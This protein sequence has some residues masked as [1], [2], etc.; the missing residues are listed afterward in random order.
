MIFSKYRFVSLLLFILFFTINNRG[1]AQTNTLNSPL[2]SSSNVDSIDFEYTLSETPQKVQ[3]FF[4]C[5]DGP[6]LTSG[7]LRDTLTIT[8]NL[9]Y[10]LFFITE[11]NLTGNSF[12][13]SNQTQLYNGYYSVYTQFKR[14]TTGD[15][16]NSL[17]ST[18]VYLDHSTNAPTLITPSSNTSL[19]TQIPISLTL[20]E[21]PASGTSKLTFTNTAGSYSNTLVLANGTLSQ[22]FTLTSNS[23][24]TSGSIASSTFPTLPND[25]YNITLSYQD[26]FNHPAVTA[27]NSNVLIQ[28]STTIPN[29]TSPSTGAVFSSNNSPTFTYNLPSAPL[30]GTA[31]LS[32]TSSSGSS[33][34]YT[35]P[36][37][38]GSGTYTITSN[39][40]ADG[41]YTATVSYQD[42]LS[43]PVSSTSV[44][45]L[46]FD[47]I[48]LSP[49]INAP[50]TSTVSTGTV[51]FTYTL[52]ET[53]LNNSKQLKISQNGTIITILTV[54][55][56]NTSTL[57]LN[58]KNL[59]T[60]ASAITTITGTSNIPDGTYS[61]TFSYQDQYSNAVASASI[62]L[63]IDTRTVAPILSS[64]L[65]GSYYSSKIPISLTLG[66]SYLS[67]SAKIIFVNSNNLRD[68][69]TLVDNIL[70][71][72]FTITTKN[73]LN[74]NIISTTK[75]I[76]PDEIY[77][78]IIQYQD[79]YG[80]P[81][82]S[83]AVSNILI[84]NT[85]PIPS[86]TSP[87]NGGAFSG[88]SKISVSYNLPSAPFSGTALLTLSPGY[89]Y[90]LTNTQ[91]G[92]YTIT[93]NLPV[94]GTYTCTVSY[95]DFLGNPTASAS[96]KIIVQRSTPNPKIIE[97]VNHAY[98]S[99]YILFKDS[100]SVANAS[101]TKKLTISKDTSLLTTIVLNNNLADSFYL[102]IHHLSQSISNF[103]SISGVDSLLDGIYILNLS[104]QDIYGNPT[105]SAI[106]TIHI[107]TKPLI[108]VLSHQ[109]DIVYVPFIETLTFN[110]PVSYIANRPIISGLINDK[111]SATLGSLSA[112][113]NNNIFSFIVTPLEVGVIKLQSPFIGIA[114]DSAGNQS[115]IIAIDSIKYIDTTIVLTP[116]ISGKFSFCQGDSTILTSTAA[117]TYLWSNG[118]TTR[119][120]VI[121]QS[122]IYSLKTTYDN[123]IK[124]SSNNAII[125][126]NPI[127]SAPTLSRDASNNLVAS[128]NGIT[129]YKDGTALT[130]TTQ[131]IKPTTPGSYTVKTT[132]NGCT[133]S[134]S[135]PYYYLVTDIINLSADEFIKLAPN[136]FT[137]RLNFD[138]VLKGYQKLNLEVFDLATG[139]KVSSLQSL[140]AGMPIYLGQL[141]AGTYVIKVSTGDN[142]IVQQFKVVKL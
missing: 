75:N 1:T 94:D 66:E 61:L 130:D 69:L 111:Q 58:F 28:S 41:T 37:Q 16:I 140:S 2:S 84:Q 77:N 139:A 25:S 27:T 93:S 131:K 13:T 64:P 55:D 100:I 19:S 135:I 136:P 42:F 73:V 63:A 82:N 52:P 47:H 8:N 126:L 6:C 9:Q 44:S 12:F 50:L 122:G 103:Q 10:Q 86:I 71:Q 76:I 107:D 29:L 31:F 60:S 62:N 125:T 35:L 120:I 39:I 24:A 22:T 74:T 21:I 109:T 68:T 142:K 32:L 101:G 4:I 102:D 114:Y 95:Q 106:D 117:N 51:T 20:G 53:Q 46:I 110:K 14:V 98:F 83:V 49:I 97:P 40:P 124:G 81:V 38:A 133:S 7:H 17:I 87:I 141:S 34:V 129:W 70:S 118:A 48:T 91:I 56:V 26:I 132:Q 45:N 18:N 134:A 123:H 112:N 89:T 108:G 104:Y 92:T 57:S 15:T 43:N 137:N 78:I 90:P 80:N 115:Q 11:S 113:A 3:V 99:S 54:S 138:F 65:S 59:V 119:S 30:S 79:Q 36:N 72:T 88:S 121:K 116:L 127:P 105:A 23:L 85:T 96:V 33:Y 5:T 128:I 67:G